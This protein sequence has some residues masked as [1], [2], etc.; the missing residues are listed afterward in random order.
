MES[1]PMH[2]Q[3][4]KG[5]SRKSITLFSNHTKIEEDVYVTRK[6]RIINLAF[7]SHKSRW[8]DAISG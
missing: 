4:L 2:K 7:H 8:Q 5:S 6:G 1:K 3:G